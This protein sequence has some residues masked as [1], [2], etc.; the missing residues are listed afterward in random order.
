MWNKRPSSG[1][2][3][4]VKKLASIVSGIEDHKTIDSYQRFK[5]RLKL[6]EALRTR[7]VKTAAMDESTIYPLKPLLSLRTEPGVLS[8][9]E[10]VWGGR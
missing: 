9:L 10:E 8:R 1:D 4:W 5:S 2:F 6:A 3:S 7:L